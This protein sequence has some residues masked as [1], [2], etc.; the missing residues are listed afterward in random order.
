MPLTEFAGGEDFLLGASRAG[1]QGK[2]QTY[3][4]L[5]QLRKQEREATQRMLDEQNKARRENPQLGMGQRFKPAGI[6]RTGPK[7]ITMKDYEAGNI[8][9]EDYNDMMSRARG[10]D[11]RVTRGLRMA[12]ML[13]L[14]SVSRTLFGK[15]SPFAGAGGMLVGEALR[16]LMPESNYKYVLDEYGQSVGTSAYTSKPSKTDPLIAAA[17]VTPGRGFGPALRGMMGAAK[18]FDRVVPRPVTAGFA[19]TG[20]AGATMAQPDEAKA[21]SFGA[22]IKRALKAG[23]VE[24]VDRVQDLTPEQ[25]RGLLDDPKWA[26]WIISR[27]STRTRR[28]APSYDDN[29][30]MRHWIKFSGEADNMSYDQARKKWSSSGF[31]SQR[32]TYKN[33]LIESGTMIPHTDQDLVDKA[34]ELLD[35]YTDE[36]GNWRSSTARREFFEGASGSVKGRSAFHLGH[37]QSI[38]KGGLLTPA[39]TYYQRG[40][41][42]LKEGIG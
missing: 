18:A 21:V 29:A 17:T 19:A 27:S 33:N 37:K 10:Q 23:A 39:N 5:A 1:K 26:K 34:A 28:A 15:D 32:E 11:P 9:T 31:K 4:A 25:V 40:P 20:V 8:S 2:R 30:A 36:A 22:N 42:N 6:E 38:A 24:G 7:D 16:R 3:A 41:K 13:G 35:S 14:T 12:D